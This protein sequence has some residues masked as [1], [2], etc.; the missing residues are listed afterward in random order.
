MSMSKARDK[1]LFTLAKKIIPLMR[2]Q[3]NIKTKPGS[4]Q[5][6]NKKKKCQITLYRYQ[7]E[8]GPRRA[9]NDH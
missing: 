4:S 6:F 8:H 3:Y 2:R 5:D 7:G 1:Q 9:M